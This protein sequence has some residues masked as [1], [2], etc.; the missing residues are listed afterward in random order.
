M[1]TARAHRPAGGEPAPVGPDEGASPRRA[2]VLGA[3]AGLLAALAAAAPL[4]AQQWLQMT[5]AR[6]SDGVSRM[7]LRV[8]YAAGH[9]EI[10]PAEEGLLYQARLRYRGD[11]FRPLRSYELDDGAARVRLGLQGRDGGE[12]LHLDWRDLRDLDL[13]ELDEGAGDGRLDV[14]I[15]RSVPTTLEVRVG[16]AEAEMELGGLPLTGLSL[17]TGASETTIR[18]DAPNPVE[19]DRMEIRSGAAEIE[20]LELANAAAREIRVE[21]AVGDVTLD[22]TGAWRRDVEASVKLGLGS[23]HLRIPADVGVRL[24]KSSLLSSFSGFGLERAEDDSY[25]SENWSEAEHRLELSVDAAFGSID[26][27]RVD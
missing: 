20:L 15:G 2:A 8:E 16:A 7:D 19:M 11:S 3:A 25:R 18:F 9:L 23:L 22:F 17:E 13:G 4:P 6:Q 26:V 14:G 1:R 24:R 21:G 27:D 5:T 12:E 10:G